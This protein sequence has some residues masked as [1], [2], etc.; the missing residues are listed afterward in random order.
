MLSGIERSV[1]CD[2][3]WDVQQKQEPLYQWEGWKESPP[4]QQV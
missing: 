1:D 4:E 2:G 3:G